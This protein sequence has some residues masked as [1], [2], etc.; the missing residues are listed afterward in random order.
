MVINSSWLGHWRFCGWLNTTSLAAKLK[1]EPELEPYGANY[2]P[3]LSPL[4]RN[5]PNSNQ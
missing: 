3:L 1:V 4:P 5:E 2:M